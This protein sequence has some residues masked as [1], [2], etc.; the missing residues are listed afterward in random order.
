M[1]SGAASSPSCRGAISD[2]TSSSEASLT[3]LAFGQRLKNFSSSGRARRAS[4]TGGGSP[5]T[6]SGEA[7]VPEYRANVSGD[8]NRTDTEAR[9]LSQ[10]G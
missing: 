4:S 8:G 9:R 3:A 1:M 2:A 7:S 5:H 10:T 6:S